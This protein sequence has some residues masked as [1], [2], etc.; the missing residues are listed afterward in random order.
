MQE[1]FLFQSAFDGAAPQ[2]QAR[3][4]GAAYKP[5]AHARQ[6]ASRSVSADRPQ[7]HLYRK[8]V[9]NTRAKPCHAPSLPDDA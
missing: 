3:F 1:P 6:W 8:C 7:I 4:A 2:W 5:R 9:Q